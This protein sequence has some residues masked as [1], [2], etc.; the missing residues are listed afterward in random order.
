[1]SSTAPQRGWPWR[2]VRLV[3]V[4][5]GPKAVETG[6]AGDGVVAR[7]PTQLALQL[8]DPPVGLRELE[9]ELL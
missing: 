5:L 7:V 4:E 8:Y 9:F 3:D 2:R 6:Q 1:M